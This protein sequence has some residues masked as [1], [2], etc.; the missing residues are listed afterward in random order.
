MIHIG[1]DEAPRLRWQQCPKCQQLIKSQGLKGDGKFSAE[2]KLQGYFTKEIERFA[3]ANGRRIIGWDEVLEGDVAP[4]TIIMSWRGTEGG[5]QASQQGH[6]VIMAPTSHF[7]F[8]Y[9][10]ADFKTGGEPFLIGGYLPIEKTYSFEPLPS[11]ST[12]QMQAHILGVQANLWTEYIAYPSLVEYQVLPRMGALAECQW[13]QPEKKDFQDFKQ[14][15]V[16]LAKT[17]H[18][19]GWTFAKHLFK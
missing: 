3:N 17:Y 15:A 13:M 19:N 5:I 11:N 9:Y 2:V 10:Q 18:L 14:R 12:Q 8:D 7:Y 16:Q 4:S 6:D 1:G